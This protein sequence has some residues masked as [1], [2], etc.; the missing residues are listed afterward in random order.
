MTKN[1]IDIS[2]WQGDV[3][4]KNVNT[5]FCIIRAGYG[6]DL[7]QK[8]TYFEEYYN[9]CKSRGIPCGVYWYSYA[10]TVADAEREANTC[11]QVIKGKQF[12][13]PIYFDVEEQNAFYTGKANVSAMIKA[14]CNKIEAA[15]YYAGLYISASPLNTYVDDS[16]KSRYTIWVAH[17]G[18]NKPA[19]SGAYDIWQKSSSGKISGIGG[20]V[21]LDECYKDFPTI[22]K[23]AGLN[24]FPKPAATTTKPVQEAAK[25]AETTQ[26]AKAKKTVELT[27]DGKKYKGTLEEV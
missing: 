3:D 19:Y 14:F 27:I 18:V 7:S 4:W 16:V 12:E 26:P 13:Y 17:Y 15:G 1:G 22:I 8:D 2:Q 20:N 5:E 10:T 21:D 9:G 25:P 11:L 23:N 6:R 24:G